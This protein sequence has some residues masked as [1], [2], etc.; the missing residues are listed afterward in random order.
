MPLL[1]K[2]QLS[3]FIQLEN[4]LL[5]RNHSTWTAGEGRILPVSPLFQPPASNVYS[6]E[7]W[8]TDAMYLEGKLNPLKTVIYFRLPCPW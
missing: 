7:L 4:A 3:R 1:S 2:L 6:G 8:F 5:E